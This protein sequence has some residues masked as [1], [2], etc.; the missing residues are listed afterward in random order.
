MT[1]MRSRVF[2]VFLSSPF[3]DMQKERDYLNDH[4]FAH[5]DTELTALG[6]RLQVIDLYIGS[7][8]DLAYQAALKREIEEAG[9]VNLRIY[10]NTG[11]NAKRETADWLEALDIDIYQDLRKSIFDELTDMTTTENAELPALAIME[12]KSVHLA[13][14]TYLWPQ[15]EHLASWLCIPCF[16]DAFAVR[17]SGW[18]CAAPEICHPGAGHGGGKPGR[19]RIACTAHFRAHSHPSC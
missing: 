18:P 15:T 7:N 1:M 13:N 12:A 11:W 2:R 14:G 16:F 10:E 5:L 3:R 9:D 6:Y 8:K 4:A 17:P 19:I